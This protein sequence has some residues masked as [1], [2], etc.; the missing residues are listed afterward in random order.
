MEILAKAA[1][2]STPR[3]ISKQFILYESLLS[4]YPFLYTKRTSS[5]PLDQQAWNSGYYNKTIYRTMSTQC[6]YP[7]VLCTCSSPRGL[8]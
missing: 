5:L 6:T 3:M 8:T 4:G 1:V 7:P 2:F